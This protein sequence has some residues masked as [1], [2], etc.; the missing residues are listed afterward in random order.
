ML[1]P[2]LHRHRDWMPPLVERA[3]RRNGSIAARMGQ[4]FFTIKVIATLLQEG[5]KGSQGAAIRIDGTLALR[6]PLLGGQP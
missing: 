5:A 1:A 6:L 4:I 2:D 3:A